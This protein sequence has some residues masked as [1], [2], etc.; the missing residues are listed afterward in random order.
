MLSLK[1]RGRFRLLDKLKFSKKLHKK[2]SEFQVWEEGVYP[3]QIDSPATMIDGLEYIH[4]NPLKAGFVDD[5]SI[6]DILL[7]E[8]MQE[9]ME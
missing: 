3:K 8:I 1:E 2:Q 9:M 4:A 6:G 7:L 5:P